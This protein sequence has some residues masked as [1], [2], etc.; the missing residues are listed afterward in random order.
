MIRGIHYFSAEVKPKFMSS[1]G[2]ALTKAGRFQENNYQVFVRPIDSSLASYSRPIKDWFS[3][4]HDDI[5]QSS[6]SFSCYLNWGEIQDLG[7]PIQMDVDVKKF[8]K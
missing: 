3:L 7:R 8:S 4:S 2:A 1:Q 5:G 6:L